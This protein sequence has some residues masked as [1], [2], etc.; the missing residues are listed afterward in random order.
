MLSKLYAAHANG[1][2]AIGV[3]VEASDD[4]SGVK[5]AQEAGIL[6]S[7]I[8]KQHAIKLAV[9]A[10]TTVLSVDQVCFR[11]WDSY[12]ASSDYHGQT[13]RRTKAQE[14]PELGR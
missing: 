1:G 12:R 4:G 7:L 13:G 5:D 10:A 14:E 3:D 8:I 11:L 9:H 6:D 2:V